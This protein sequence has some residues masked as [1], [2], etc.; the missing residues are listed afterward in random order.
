MTNRPLYALAF[1]CLLFS[2][3]PISANNTT[4]TDEAFMFIHKY[5]DIAIR[6]MHR[7]GIP[8]SIT[9]AQAIL[10]SSW[11][12]GELA[13]NSNN[14]FGIKCK[15]W[16]DGETYYIEDDDYNSNNELIKSCF[17]KYDTIEE[18]YVDHSNFLINNS[19]YARLFQLDSK[20]YISWAKG[21][22]DCNYATD[23]EYANKLIRN[24]E[25]YQLYEYDFMGIESTQD[26][27]QATTQV[28]QVQQVEVVQNQTI[29]LFQA[30]NQVQTQTPVQELGYNEVQETDV[31]AAF[32]IPDN[33]VR[34]SKRV[35]KPVQASKPAMDNATPTVYAEEVYE[36]EVVEYNPS[37]EEVY[38]ERS[39]SNYIVKQQASHAIINH[40]AYVPIKNNG[41]RS[42]NSNDS[43]VGT[44]RLIKNRRL[45]R[46]RI[47]RK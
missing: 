22:K 2:Y 26:I 15:D 36:N 6:E 21:L 12:K 16:W 24:I 3:L 31:P 41:V 42:Y 46:V 44:N 45:P 43:K 8:A 33:Y 14:F 17:R 30:S 47:N 32:R 34:N 29:N 23:P 4:T 38:E 11:G 10:E 37:V 7:S 25:L 5:K 40:Q 20:D 28:Q 1:L 13:V 19:R 39:T 9:I 18:S 35:S 27:V